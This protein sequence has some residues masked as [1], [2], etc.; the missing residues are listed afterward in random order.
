MDAMDMDGGDCSSV[1][2][3]DLESRIE[4]SGTL[5]REIDKEGYS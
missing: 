3:M 4:A 1:G 2:D 5:V